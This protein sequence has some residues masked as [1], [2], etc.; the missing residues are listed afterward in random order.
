MALLALRLTDF[1]NIASLRIEVDGRDVFLIGDNGQGKTN[2]LEAVYLLCYGASFRTRNDRDLIANGSREAAVWGRLAAGGE[3]RGVG[4][5]LGRSAG[6]RI[7]IDG[8][9]IRDR[10]ALIEFAP[11]IA[12]THEDLR[13]IDG[14]PE[15][16]RSL[17]DH[18]LSLFNPSFIDV[19]R[20]YRRAL[21]ARNAL[22]RAG[23][24][25]N[26]EVVDVYE[27]VLA[28]AG[29]E[30]RTRRGELCAEFAAVFADLCDRIGGLS[31]TNIEYRPS[32]RE[33]ASADD[34]E[35]EL[36]G[37]RERDLAAGTTTSGPHRDDFRITLGQARFSAQGS[38]GQKRLASLVLRVAQAEF[39]ERTT[40]RR[41]I[42]LLDDVL[43]ELDAGKREQFLRH[44][45][46]YDQAFFT[47]LPDEPYH[48][49]GGA[50]TINLAVSGGAFTPCTAPATC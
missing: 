8:K 16:R 15:R 11:A 24:D 40:G 35:A 10:A 6:K 2:F 50:G 27:P 45:P 29:W 30:I 42:L 41:P 7:A 46:S 20:R 22:L 13:F 18:T 38:T 33:A 5:G 12:F 37:R 39:F 3:E 31:D 9:R 25:R 17:F 48:R 23:D 4:V 1:R 28:A 14:D 36:R 21:R 19:L 44:L 43:L 47:F 26:A 32:W 34:A 49:Y